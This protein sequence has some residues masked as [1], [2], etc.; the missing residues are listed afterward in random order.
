AG[1]AEEEAKKAE[2]AMPEFS[3][4]TLEGKAVT[5][6]TI[7]GKPAVFVLMQTA[8]NMCRTEISD[9]DALSKS[10]SYKEIS[11]FIV[12]VDIKPDA[13]LPGYL[14]SN[15]ISMTALVDPEFTF[16]PKFGLTFTPSAVFVDKS[17]KVAAIS[18]GYKADGFEKAKGYLDM[19]K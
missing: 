12:N 5:N 3:L 9:M 16:G 18:R 6:K 15:A 19:I 1:I 10:D 7:K 11:F 4:N 14:K 13:T 2:N 8:C 17:G